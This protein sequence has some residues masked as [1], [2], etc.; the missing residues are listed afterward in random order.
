MT[1]HQFLNLYSFSFKID[2]VEYGQWLDSVKIKKDV[3]GNKFV[4]DMF[5]FK[6]D[7]TDLL[8]MMLK[9]ADIEIS[10]NRSNSYEPI[11]KISGIISKVFKKDEKIILFFESNQKINWMRKNGVSITS[12]SCTVKDIL[13][14]YIEKIDDFYKHKTKTLF[15]INYEKNINKYKYENI[16]M[17]IQNNHFEVFEKTARTYFL[18][19]APFYLFIDDYN[20]TD[21]SHPVSINIYDLSDIKSLRAVMVK[22]LNTSTR[23]LLKSSGTYYDSKIYYNVANVQKFNNSIYN[24]ANLKHRHK[25]DSKNRFKYNDAPDTV[26]AAENRQ[27]LAKDFFDKAAQFYKY[28]IQD[29]DVTK[30]Q[31]GYRFVDDTSST[32]IQYAQAIV[33]V[34]Y[35]F[36]TSGVQDSIENKGEFV[37]QMAVFVKFTTISN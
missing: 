33:D 22:E 34:E 1:K 32:K 9:P 35:K 28:E 30:F 4:E 12:E 11:V 18:T 37:N 15:F 27:Q 14:K 8:N 3:T 10:I 31:L 2:N 17:P 25:F 19:N 23:T 24:Y 13:Q 20:F 5:V 21:T 7:E 36:L 26:D 29:I 16:L 6:K